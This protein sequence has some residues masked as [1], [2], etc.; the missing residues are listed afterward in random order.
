M[1]SD[2]LAAA[3]WKNTK[4]YM[5]IA[6]KETQ[7]KYYTK[8]NSCEEVLQLVRLESKPFGTQS[9]KM[10]AEIFSLGPRSSTQNDG[11]KNGKK[12]EIKAARFWGGKDDCKWQ[13]LEPDHDYEYALLALLDFQGWKVWGI[14]KSLLMGEL[15]EKAIVTSQGKQGY[16]VNKNA[17][18]P[19]LTP[20]KTIADLD[21]F[22]Q[23]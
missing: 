16:W 20:I 22:I 3:H 1:E 13:H 14:K 15:R 2:I 6:D 10:I 9:E 18:L 7:I 21:T 11:V 5:E 12:I 4:T 19:Y 23:T 17:I 8:M